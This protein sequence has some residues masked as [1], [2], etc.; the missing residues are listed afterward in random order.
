VD[1]VKELL[2]EQSNNICEIKNETHLAYD[3]ERIATEQTLK[4]YFTKKM[5]QE[6]KEHP[7]QKEE[8]LNS[9]EMTV[10]LME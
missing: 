6:I 7:E 1:K 5:L 9:L 3:F 8:I 10:Q 2:Y 4:G